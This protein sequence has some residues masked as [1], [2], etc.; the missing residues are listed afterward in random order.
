M[1]VKVLAPLV[2]G[3]VPRLR[4]ELRLLKVES[5]SP[6]GDMN[7][8]FFVFFCFEGLLRLCAQ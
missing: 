1:S 3:Q 4:P 8:F 2:K 5:D 7:V 6:L